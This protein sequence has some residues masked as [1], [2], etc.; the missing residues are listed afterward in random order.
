[1]VNYIVYLHRFH[2][3]GNLNRK[4][5]VYSFGIVLLELITGQPAIKGA[6]DNFIHILQW[7][8]PKLESGDIQAIVD[9]MLQGKLNTVSAWK[10]VEIA[11]SCVSPTAN[12]RPDTSQI[13]AELKEC[14][15]MEIDN[16]SIENSTKRNSSNSLQ[17]SSIQSDSNFYI[18]AR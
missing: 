13:V 16:E 11:M 7:V 18:F 2:K 9:P 15:A 3:S 17:L 14:L 5:D 4:S 10:F 12:Q 6:P 8:T 1:M